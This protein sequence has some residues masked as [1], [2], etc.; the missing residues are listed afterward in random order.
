MMLLCCSY[1][2]MGHIDRE[3]K[4]SVSGYSDQQLNPRQHQY[5]VSSSNTLSALLQS[6][7]LANEYD[8][9]TPY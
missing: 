2:A 3:A 5:V 6:T 4:N 9:G 1:V 7:Q 8:T